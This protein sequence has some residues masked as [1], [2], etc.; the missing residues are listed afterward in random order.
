MRDELT[1]LEKQIL[2]KRDELAAFRVANGI[3]SLG[4]ENLYENQSLARFKALNKSYSTASDEAV[5]SKGR[6]DAI[7]KAIARGKTVVPA[8]DKKGMSVLELRLQ[9][10]REQLAQFDKKYTRE[11]LA[12][13][14][15][16]NVL[17]QQIEDLEREI[18]SIRNFGKSIALRSE[19]LIICERLTQDFK[20]AEPC[21]A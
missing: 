19:D 6:L 15:G 5:K 3:T 18:Q 20:L 1:G 12:L 14:P 17:P 4:R 21:P 13:N 8:E 10:L 9:K 7:N 16:L 2:I 11:Y